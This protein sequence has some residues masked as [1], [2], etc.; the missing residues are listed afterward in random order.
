MPDLFDKPDDPL[1]SALPRAFLV[2]F[3]LDH[4]ARRI[5]PWLRR[6][7][8]AAE[9]AVA[10]WLRQGWHQRF[11]DCRVLND[12]RLA[13]VK[14]L[15]DDELAPLDLAWAIRAYQQEC[16]TEKG[17]LAN[18]AMR[19]TFES[20]MGAS[21][22]VEHYIGPGRKLADA[23]TDRRR[24]IDAR[25]AERAE[26]QTIAGLR[27][28]FDGLSKPDQMVL[29]GRAVDSLTAQNRMRGAGALTNPL[30][31]AKVLQLLQ[32]DDAKSRE[33]A[34]PAGAVLG[35]VMGG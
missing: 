8:T 30:V 13:A 17:R 5:S 31:H 7:C 2:D 26:T 32:E 28:A 3:K 12:T 22:V 25:A 16:A 33:A 14:R 23:E 35:K 24:R 10:E 1:L 34:T 11:Q 29:V 27:A 20:F 6:K 21:G 18:P 9:I 4:A 15:L 19:R